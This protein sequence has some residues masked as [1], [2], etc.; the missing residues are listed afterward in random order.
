MYT[1]EIFK[2]K[3]FLDIVEIPLQNKGEISKFTVIKE[4]FNGEIIYIKKRNTYK[5]LTFLI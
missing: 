1:R 3:K 2:N 5:G 4:E